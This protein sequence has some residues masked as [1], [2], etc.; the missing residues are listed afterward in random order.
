M[1][2]IVRPDVYHRY[3]KVMRNCFPLIV[4][5]RPS[6]SNRGSLILGQR[7]SGSL[8]ISLESGMRHFHARTLQQTL[9]LLLQGDDHRLRGRGQGSRPPRPNSEPCWPNPG[10]WDV[11]APGVPPN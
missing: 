10:P 5:R 7:A 9:R 2:V 11:A 4:E 8:S 1:N 3:Y 6:R